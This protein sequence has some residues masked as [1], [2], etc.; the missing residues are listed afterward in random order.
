MG[1]LMKFPRTVLFSFGL[2]VCIFAT[3]VG[4]AG[5]DESDPDSRYYKWSI[6]EVVR[7]FTWVLVVTYIW[8][9]VFPKALTPKQHKWL[10]FLLFLPFPIPPIMIGL[11]DPA[12]DIYDG[13]ASATIKGWFAATMMVR[14]IV[15]FVILPAVYYHYIRPNVYRA[16]KKVWAIAFYVIAGSLFT[17]WLTVTGDKAFL[18]IVIGSFMIFWAII[19]VLDRKETKSHKRDISSV[20]LLSFTVT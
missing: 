1:S 2:V 15:L 16:L 12:E 19:L 3:L 9:L 20:W 10:V 5:F 6:L 13:T 14:G 18:P 7:S 4:R 17:L 8:R 11:S